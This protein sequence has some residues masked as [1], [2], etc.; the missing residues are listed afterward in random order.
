M[1]FFQ[2][3]YGWI[4]SLIKFGGVIA[5]IFIVLATGMTFYE[6]VSRSL[7]N[8][9]TIWATE[10]TIYAIMGSCFIGAA[11]A[12]R[13]DAHIKVDLLLHN[14]SASVRRWM[15]IASALIGLLF[16][17]VFCYLSWEHVQQSMELGFTSASLLQIPMYI[18][19]MLLPIGGVLLG[20]AFLLQLVD[21]IRGQEGGEA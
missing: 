3:L 19:E 5:G 4:D 10:L 2:V 8:A 12:V 13:V 11:Y 16:S 21:Y 15:L 9:P 18:P 17:L 1:K 14:V 6:I 20:L 7:F